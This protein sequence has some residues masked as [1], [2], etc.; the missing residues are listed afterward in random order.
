MRLAT[1]RRRAGI[2]GRSSIAGSTGDSHPALWW[3]ALSLIPTA[4]ICRRQAALL[5]QQRMDAV[6][7][8]NVLENIRRTAVAVKP[9]ATGRDRPGYFI[10]FFVKARCSCLVVLNFGELP[11]CSDFT[12]TYGDAAAIC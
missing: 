1:A 11:V 7:L 9:S 4:P 3:V 2:W 8:R 5:A 10:V 6:A 12:L